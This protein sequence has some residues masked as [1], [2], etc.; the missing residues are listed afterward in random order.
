MTVLSQHSGRQAE[1]AVELC[2]PRVD[3]SHLDPQFRPGLGVIHPSIIPLST[4]GGGNART[5]TANRW[6]HGICAG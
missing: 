5:T 6:P 2:R 3:L 1:N 4:L